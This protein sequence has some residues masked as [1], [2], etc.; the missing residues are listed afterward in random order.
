MPTQK[1]KWIDRDTAAKDLLLV[2][3]HAPPAVS[4][5]ALSLLRS[6]RSPS[7]IPE[8]TAIANDESRDIWERRYALRA[9]NVVPRNL[10]MSKIVQHM[11]E[12]FSKRSKLYRRASASRGY[13]SDLSPDL[14]NDIIDIVDKHPENRNWF[15]NVLK[16]MDEPTIVYDYLTNALHYRLSDDFRRLLLDLLLAQLIKQPDLLTLGTV[17]DLLDYETNESR[18]FLNAQLNRIIELCL[19]SE[20]DREW[21]PLATEWNELRDALVKVKPELEA[22]ITAFNQEWDTN[23]KNRELRKQQEL[24]SIQQNPIYQF[25]LGLY[26]AAQNGDK[27]AYDK[28]KRIANKWN[29]NIPLRAVATHFIGKL[30]PKYNSLY[31]L[32]YLLKHAADDWGEPPCHS[33]I[34]FE[35]GEALMQHHSSEVWETLVDA[36]FINPRNILSNF[37]QSWIDHVTD[38]LSGDQHDYNGSRWAIENRGW[39]YSL[40][41]LDIRVLEPYQ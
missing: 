1:F 34:R 36:F 10:D 23:R 14:L 37:M 17:S 15:I 31:T 22:P 20:Q 24:E 41:E 8:L 35:A 39:F 16:R 26:E 11:E 5:R 28:L 33:P 7:I 13:I 40:T 30:L 25:L 2:A 21:L 18:A 4:S 9:I 3:Y 6:I 27:A 38:A 19:S 12:A 29:G 32:L